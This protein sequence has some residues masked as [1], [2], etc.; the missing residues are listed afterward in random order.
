MQK[1]LN[2][3]ITFS[4]PSSNGK[5]GKWCEIRIEDKESGQNVAI[6]K[7]S[8]EQFFDVMSNRACI[9]C[10]LEVYDNFEKLGKVRERTG[11]ILSDERLKES[12][13]SNI[14][15]VIDDNRGM[16]VD[17]WKFEGLPSDESCLSQ[18]QHQ[19]TKGTFKAYMV[20]YVDAPK[21]DN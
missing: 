10:Q 4:F 19:Q 12:G 15:A 5:V 11:V 7:L 14:Q 2:G 13:L 21:G 16:E 6:I 9:D 1:N 18:G 17:G 3:E 8:P 20:R